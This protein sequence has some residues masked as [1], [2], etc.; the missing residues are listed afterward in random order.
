MSLLKILQLFQCR[1]DCRIEWLK[2][3]FVHLRIHAGNKFYLKLNTHFRFFFFRSSLYPFGSTKKYSDSD[4]GRNL[5]ETFAHGARTLHTF[6]AKQQNKFKHV[7][8]EISHLDWPLF[9]LLYYNQCISFCRAFFRTRCGFFFFFFFCFLLL[10]LFHVFNSLL[11]PFH[12]CIVTC[13]YVLLALFLPHLANL[14][15]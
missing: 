3:D 10:F 2:T 12:K 7:L 4:N 9:L 13:I 8:N 1:R 5:H 15:Y 11:E 6:H 14:V